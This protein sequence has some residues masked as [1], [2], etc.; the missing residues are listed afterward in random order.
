MRQTD[1]GKAGEMVKVGFKLDSGDWDNLEVEWLW[2]A[3]VAP[4]E[5]RIQSF[6]FFV[7]G[8]S[9]GD[10]VATNEDRNRLFFKRVLRR[11]GHSTYRLLLAQGLTVDSSQFHSAWAPLQELGCAFELAKITWLSVDI[12]SEVDIQVAYSHLEA[13]EG[14]GIWQVFE[15]FCGH[16]IEKPN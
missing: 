8:I 5:Y 1:A 12:P 14:D 6:P 4:A 2:A 11:G 15:G 7:Y 16:V 9:F 3:R 13:A 10:I